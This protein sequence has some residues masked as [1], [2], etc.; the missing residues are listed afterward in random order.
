PHRGTV[1]GKGVFDTGTSVTISAVPKDGYAFIRWSDDVYDDERELLMDR[2]INLIA[3]FSPVRRVMFDTNGGPSMDGFDVPVGCSFSIPVYSG[4]ME[5]MDMVGWTDGVH[6]YSSDSVLTMVPHDVVLKAIWRPAERDAIFHMHDRDVTVHSVIGQPIRIPEISQR[7]GYRFAGWD[8]VIPD[9][10]PDMDMEF[11]V[12][13]DPVTV[14]YVFDTCGGSVIEDMVLRP[15]Y[16]VPDIGDPTREGYLFGGWD[17]NIPKICG[18]EDRRFT[19]IWN[20]GTYRMT[21]DTVGGSTIPTIIGVYGSEIVLPENPTKK[22]HRFSGWSPSPGDT[23]P[24][25]D[26]LYTAVW[27]R[28]IYSV[29]FGGGCEPVTVTGYYGDPVDVPD[30]TGERDGYVLKG[31]ITDVP[32]TFPDHDIVILGM[33]DPMVFTVTFDMGDGIV[34]SKDVECGSSIPEVDPPEYDDRKFSGWSGHVGPMPAHDI[35]LSAIWVIPTYHM[36]F[37]SCGEVVLD[38]YMEYGS[39]V[40]APVLSSDGMV[41]TGWVPEVPDKVPSSDMTFRAV[42]APIPEDNVFRGN[43]EIMSVHSM[44]ETVRVERDGGWIAEFVS[45]GESLVSVDRVGTENGSALYRVDVSGSVGDVHLWVPYAC[46]E[47]LSLDV[48]VRSSSG[49]YTVEGRSVVYDD[50]SYAEMTVP[51]DCLFFVS[52]ISKEEVTGSIALVNVF[53]VAMAVLITLMFWRLLP[54]NRL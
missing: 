51:S 29:V 17:Q 10:M 8:P 49:Q 21:F 45:S 28:N 44:N 23:I 22:G 53:A 39:D 25:K 40:A 31:W 38:G 7:D 1:T 24:S 36:V 13:W 37:V 52:G 11:T 19:A 48:S 54:R 30:G 3:V 14:R 18:P 47:G 35:L 34:V 42:W 43:A 26:T 46:I 2:D 41:H 27:E 6:R 16:P 9:V 33:W 20:P 5:G 50:V 32:E 12:S 15:G 4:I